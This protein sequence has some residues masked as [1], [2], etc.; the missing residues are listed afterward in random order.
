M[1]P[2]LEQFA[3]KYQPE[4]T[5]PGF[6]CGWDLLRDV[7]MDAPGYT[8]FRIFDL[9]EFLRESRD[10]GYDHY[11][12]VTYDNGEV[13]FQVADSKLYIGLGSLTAVCTPDDFINELELVVEAYN[14]QLES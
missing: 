2:S 5:D 11:A 10:Q 13:A 8:E 1:R 4:N 12:S 7:F 6:R 9:L 3:N 14:A